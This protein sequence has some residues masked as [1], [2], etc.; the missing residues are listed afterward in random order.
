ME[1]TVGAIQMESAN[2]DIDGN[3]SRALPLVEEAAEKGA[4][5]ICLAQPFP[6]FIRIPEDFHFGGK[7]AGDLLV[8][9]CNAHHQIRLHQKGGF[10]YSAFRAVMALDESPHPLHFGKIQGSGGLGQIP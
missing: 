3:L 2:V 5:L 4:T 8:H 9:S 1:L 7:M 6:G 10:V